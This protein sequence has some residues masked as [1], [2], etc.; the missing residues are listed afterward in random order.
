[1]RKSTKDLQYLT[2]FFAWHANSITKTGY[3]KFRPAY[4]CPITGNASTYWK[5]AIK[6]TIYM[7]KKEKAK[8][9]R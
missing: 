4:N 1:M 9:S 6:A 5:Y 7:L 3:L 2:K 8:S